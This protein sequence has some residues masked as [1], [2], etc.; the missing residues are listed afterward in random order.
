MLESGE[1]KRVRDKGLRHHIT[2]EGLVGCSQGQVW[3]KNRCWGSELGV[4]YTEVNNIW[5]P[6]RRAP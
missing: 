3:V 2:Q 5:S 6:L 1:D 4:R